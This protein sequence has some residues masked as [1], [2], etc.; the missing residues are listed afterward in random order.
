MLRDILELSLTELTSN[1]ETSL[2]CSP[3]LNVD[4]FSDLVLFSCFIH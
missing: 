1:S 3:S 2:I 4:I